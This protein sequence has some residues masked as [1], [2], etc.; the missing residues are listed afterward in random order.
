MPKVRI[1]VVDDAA[2]M[3]RLIAEVIN[4]DPDLEVVGTA[5]NGRIA[6]QKL[7][8]VNPDLVTMDVEMPEM[9]GVTTLR[10]LRR[11][12]PRLPVIMFSTLTVRGA[13]TTLDA[14][15]AGATDY[16]SKPANVSDVAES[17]QRLTTELL[18]KIKAHCRKLCTPTSMGD[19]TIFMRRVK[20]S[21]TP[22][23]SPRPVP[24]GIVGIGTS[25]GGPN[26]LAEVFR[27][28]QTPPL[29]PIVL[30]QHMPPLFTGLL[31]ERLSKL[32]SV[33]VHEGRAGE[34]LL[35]GHAYLAPGGH[36]ME[37][38]R[39]AGQ[40]QVR[41]HDGPPENSCRPAV[42]VLFR[43]LATVC[44]SGTL[45]VVMTGMGADGLRGCQHLRE[46]GARILTQDEATSVVWGMPGYV[47]RAGLAEATLPLAELG[48]AI[49]QRL[50]ARPAVAVGQVKLEPEA[51]SCP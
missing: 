50:A 10:E 4:R 31:A 20:T 3:R 23:A 42:D 5:P 19:N 6:L 33:Q 22:A 1:L 43:S 44:G 40:L 21:A 13:A 36:H 30:V 18:P 11:T 35:P 29:V 47:T 49:L 37:V 46:Q 24:V 26:A 27:H 41:L 8:Q 51:I 16:V 45:A 38:E 2:V 9:D 34:P 28:F 14:L 12:H 48:P 25:T 17:A 32:S 7:T 39:V 15:G